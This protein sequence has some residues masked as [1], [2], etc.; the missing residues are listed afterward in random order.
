MLK[1]QLSQLIKVN[2]EHNFMIPHSHGGLRQ[3]VIFTVTITHS[4]GLTHPTFNCDRIIS[5]VGANGRSPLRLD[6]SLP[7][8][9]VTI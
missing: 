1:N 6:I 7:T 3:I 2:P 4:N 8:R 5:F 9:S